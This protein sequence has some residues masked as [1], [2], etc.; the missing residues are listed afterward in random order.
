MIRMYSIVA[1]NLAQHR[2]LEPVIPYLV[3]YFLC[4]I[5]LGRWPLVQTLD[6]ENEDLEQ[7]Y[8]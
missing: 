4:F 5:W 8:W 3:L 2:G 1:G 6:D 7:I